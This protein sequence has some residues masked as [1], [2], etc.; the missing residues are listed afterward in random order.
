MNIHPCQKCGAC[1][2]FF[3]VSFHWSE[4]LTE[5]FAVPAALT[6]KISP[7]Q[8][9]M[10]GTNQKN[11]RCVSLDGVIGKSISCQ[12]YENRPEPCR[13][14]LPSYEDGFVNERCEKARINKGLVILKLSDWL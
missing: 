4:I 10:M 5:S 14:F 13:T 9:A 12:I 8:S 7:H 3:R 11:P 6:E 1:C 2:A